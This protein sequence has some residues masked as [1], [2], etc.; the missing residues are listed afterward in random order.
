VDP[1]GTLLCP[2]AALTT[3]DWEE[4]G[5]PLSDPATY[6]AIEAYAPYD[7]VAQVRYPPVLAF[8]ALN[9]SRVGAHEALKY[10]SRLRSL[11]SGGPFLVWTDGTSGHGGSTDR[12]TRR[13]KDALVSAWAFKA[14]DSLREVS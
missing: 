3:V 10:I 5:N 2:D 13:W 4:W 6:A 12:T 7:N 14:L 8:T 1:L 9:D 11:G